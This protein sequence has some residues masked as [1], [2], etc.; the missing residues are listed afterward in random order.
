VRSDVFL[1]L[2]QYSTKCSPAKESFSRAH[3]LP[4]CLGGNSRRPKA[5]ERAQAR[6]PLE[7]NRIVK[8]C[9]KK[10]PEARLRGLPGSG[11]VWF[12]QVKRLTA[13]LA[14][15]LT[16]PVCGYGCG[17]IHTVI[18]SGW[19]VTQRHGASSDSKPRLILIREKFA[20]MIPGILF[21]DGG[22]TLAS[23]PL[24]LLPLH[25]VF[26]C[27]RTDEYKYPSASKSAKPRSH[28]AI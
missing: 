27:L 13:V 15:C 22:S 26:R 9:L 19:V 14:L 25:R 5:S 24:M 3:Q 23:A 11:A 7:I 10:D 21:G 8:H 4:G 1:L 18:S 2:V 17:P 28:T 20:S 16:V 12:P 6:F